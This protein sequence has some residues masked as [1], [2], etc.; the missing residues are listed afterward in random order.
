MPRRRG[1]G[2]WLKRYQCTQCG[3]RWTE[4]PLTAAER[5]ERFGTEC[6]RCNAEYVKWWNYAELRK[7]LGW[8]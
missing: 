3:A 5:K 7:R 8:P 4:Y 2:H 6:P 1:P